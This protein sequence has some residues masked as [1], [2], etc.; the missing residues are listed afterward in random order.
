[1][2]AIQPRR[3]RQRDEELGAVGVGARIRHGENSRARVLQIAHYFVFELA[4]EYALSPATCA[5]W[6][7]SLYHLSIIYTRRNII[8]SCVL[9]VLYN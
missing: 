1:M 3:G 9:L 6:V 2:L 8:R 5:R 7:A 4:S